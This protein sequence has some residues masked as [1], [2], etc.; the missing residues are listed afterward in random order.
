M[1]ANKKVDGP[2]IPFLKWAGGK[3][4]FTERHL[5]LLPEN[6]ERYIEPFLGSGAVFFSEKPTSAVLSDLN[7]D[8][9]ATYRA[10]RDNPTE[11]QALL[12]LHHNSHDKIY[13]YKV[14]G[15][16]PKDELALAA[17]FLYLNR[18]CFNGLY[19]VNLKNEFNV[20]IGTKTQVVLPTDNF[21]LISKRL[22]NVELACV[23]FEETIDQAGSGDFVFV[24]PPYTV[25][26][27]LNG[28]IKYNQ[29]IFSW[30]DQV[31]LRDAIVRAVN[32]G[33]K[34]MITNA[35]HQSVRELYQDIGEQK[36]LA[37]S[38]V[39][40]ASANF[41]ANVDELMVRTWL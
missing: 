32:R 40:A 13:Y 23:D 28:F 1:I 39:L 7:P 3:R 31:R 27:N 26:H 25:K 22:S 37:R 17:W 4:W 12:Q 19:R 34:V 8:L 2:V 16:K 5:D 35:N 36:A 38:S 29:K 41:R 20:P 14:R 11:I 30:E 24:D 18:T 9:I 21:D 10:V 33:A 6:Y 15:E